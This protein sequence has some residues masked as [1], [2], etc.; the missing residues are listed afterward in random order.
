MRSEIVRVSLLISSAVMWGNTDVVVSAFTVARTIHGKTSASLLSSCAMSMTKGFG[1]KEP[2]KGKAKSE[3]Q[4]K[5]DLEAKR[6]EE[7]AATGGQEYN[8]YVRQFGSDDKSWFPCGAVSVPRGAQVGDAIYANVDA[9]KTA[10]VRLYPRLKGFEQ[11]FE[12]GSNLKV[13][14]DD[15]IEVAV[16]RGPRPQGM[17]IGNW[18][19]TL[20]SPVDTSTIKPPPS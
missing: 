14:P 18:I 5:R 1:A 12:F 9:L 13:Y 17:S 4:T 20:L 2:A 7:I 11:E 8:I 6:Y 16:K 15:P 10:I 3:G 19:N